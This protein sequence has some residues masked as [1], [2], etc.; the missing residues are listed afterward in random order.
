MMYRSKEGRSIPITPHVSDKP[1]DLMRDHPAQLPKE[2]TRDLQRTMY[3]SS[4]VHPNLHQMPSAHDFFY[5]TNP[6][7]FI[8]SS[9]AVGYPAPLPYQSYGMLHPQSFNYTVPS[10][11]HPGMYAAPLG[12]HLGGYALPQP[13]LG[14]IGNAAH[15]PV[16]RPLEESHLKSDESSNVSYQQDSTHL[17]CSSIISH[18]VSDKPESN[19][20][21]EK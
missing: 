11:H 20:I 8:P 19:T 17:S 1:S 14:S 6:F 2:S 18:G 10:S 21:A 16:A 7:F 15:H 9:H 3:S 5:A 4:T 12:M 13:S